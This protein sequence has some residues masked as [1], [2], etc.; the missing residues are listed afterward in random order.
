MLRDVREWLDRHNT[1]CIATVDTWMVRSLP[2]PTAVVQH[3]WP[4][5]A[6]QTPLR[7]AVIFPL[8]NDGTPDTASAGI[9]RQV[10]LDRGL[11]LV[12]L[13]GGVRLA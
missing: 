9:L 2:V 8:G 3:V 12:T 1:E 5:R 13:D 6:W 4:D 7:D 11:G 10:E